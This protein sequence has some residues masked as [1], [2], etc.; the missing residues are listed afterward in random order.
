MSNAILVVARTPSGR[1]DAM[2]QIPADKRSW[3]YWHG[4]IRACRD[5]YGNRLALT[6]TRV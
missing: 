2:Y 5:E 1:V 4:V 6:I 3:R